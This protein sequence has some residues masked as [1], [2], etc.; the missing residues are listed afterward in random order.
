MAT[1]RKAVALISGGLDSMLAVRV[2]QDGHPRRRHQFLHRLLRRRAHTPFAAR[3]ASANGRSATT[4]GGR[5]ARHQAAHHRRHRGIQGRRHQLSTAMARTRTP[6]STARV[7]WYARR[8][9]GWRNRVSIS[10][11]PARSS[12]SARCRSAAIRWWRAN[13]A[14]TTA[15][16]ARCQRGAPPPTLPEREGWVQRDQL[17]NF[18]GRN[19]KP[20][21]ELATRYGLHTTPSPPAAAAFSP[22][23]STAPR[24]P[25]CGRAAAAAITNSTTSCCSRSAA[26][27]AR[28]RTSSSSSVARKETIIKAIAS[29]S[30]FRALS[31]GP[32]AARRHRA[33][34]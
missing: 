10:S 25:T 32:L 13:P 34:R 30:S 4:V 5:T 31:V 24:S 1:V 29:V 7:S 26:I 22:M 3:T 12:A 2:I 21:I 20:Q 14:P 15:C 17:L 18:N 9:N 28:A 16:C 33:G 6:A 11:S 23:N 27:C 19:R 8:A